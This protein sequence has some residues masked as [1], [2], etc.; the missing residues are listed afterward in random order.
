MN[1]FA[2]PSRNFVDTRNSRTP[3]IL[4]RDATMTD[5]G[6]GA[7]PAGK[8]NFESATRPRTLSKKKLSKAMNLSGRQKPNGTSPPGLSRGLNSSSGPVTATF[9]LKKTNVC[10]DFASLYR[11]SDV[12][13]NYTSRDEIFP[14]SLSSFKSVNR[15]FC[16]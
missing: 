5:T 12:N 10:Y 7:S 2:F 4:A 16:E 13:T 15:Y 9:G 11:L 14:R 8:R 1:S 3:R 6:A